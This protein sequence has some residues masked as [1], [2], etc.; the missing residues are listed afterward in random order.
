MLREKRRPVIAGN[1][2][3]NKTVPEAIDLVRELREELAGLRERV[4]IIVAPA[5]PA[6]QP[7]AKVLEES[8]L[9]LA[10]QNCYW[11]PSGAYTGEVS[12]PM[13]QAVGCHYVI[14]GHS[15]RR[16]FFGETDETVNKRAKA[17]VG[18]RMIPILCV[19]ETLAEREAEN[20]LPVVSRQLLAALQGFTGHQAEHFIIAYEPVWAIGTGRNATSEQAQEVHAHIREQLVILF[21]REIGER[22][23]IQYGGSVKADKAAELLAQPDVDGALVG[24]A[25]LKA[26]EFSAIVRAAS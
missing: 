6:L 13:L 4:E 26:S 10:A 5:F 8:D 12:A 18:A 9:R 19:G 7:V 3:M 11:A 23:R 16:Q 24:G 22:I 25:S 15:E 14:L 2:K 21:G 1:W 17:V 20:T